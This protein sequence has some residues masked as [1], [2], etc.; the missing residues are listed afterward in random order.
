MGTQSLKNIAVIEHRFKNHQLWAN[1]M[2][3]TLAAI[4]SAAMIGCASPEPTAPQ[5][6]LPGDRALR[7]AS[8]HLP[9]LAI[10]FFEQTLAVSEVP[11]KD[12]AGHI[13]NLR[14]LETRI[15]EDKKITANMPANE[16]LR[17]IHQYLFDHNAHR[18]A[19]DG[20]PEDIF[21]LAEV[22]RIVS[23]DLEKGNRRIGSA[24]GHAL[25]FYTLAVLFNHDVTPALAN[26]GAG[27]RIVFL[28][29]GQQIDPTSP[30]GVSDAPA[31]LP[32][33]ITP[34]ILLGLLLN[35]K[36]ASK[37]VL[38]DHENAYRTYERAYTLYPTSEISMNLA[39][40]ALLLANTK[41][42]RQWFEQATLLDTKNHAGHER[43]G[44]LES[45]E[46][47][48]QNAETHY[49]RALERCATKGMLYLKYGE[50]LFMLG[51]KSS[52]VAY[53]KRARELE[54]YNKEICEGI[55]RYLEECTS[56]K[57]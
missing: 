9:E 4:V 55:D 8:S 28:H 29:D 57:Q 13:N 40:T 27:Q 47:N 31:H 41:L 26:S 46:N 48:Y 43:L 15:R 11:E 17:A 5:R 20:L 45:A 3:T 54:A 56:R 36:G 51:Q 34:A 53:F 18:Y 2:K 12:R 25:E 50:T 38:H 23:S 10:A 30:T 19:H 49:M 6:L 44:D 42:A 1:S 39:E 37:T 33:T 35:T 24:L 7:P 32:T 52:A 14:A 22:H 16:Q 21:T